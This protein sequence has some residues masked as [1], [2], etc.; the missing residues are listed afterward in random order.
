M[1][2]FFSRKINAVKETGVNLQ[3]KA[4]R[5]ENKIAFMYNSLL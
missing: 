5:Q 4:T 1:I 3:F 2:N